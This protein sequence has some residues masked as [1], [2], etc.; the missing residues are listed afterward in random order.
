MT[1]SLIQGTIDENAIPRDAEYVQGQV[2]QAVVL[3]L[4][5]DT[6]AA[7]LSLR[8]EDISRAMKGGVVREYGKWDYKAEDEDIKRRRL[9]RMP[10]LQRQEISST[11][12]TVIS[13]TNRL[14]STWRHRM[15]EIMLYVRRRRAPAI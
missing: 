10:S 15:L 5:T 9:R 7:V 2:V 8:R 12:S 4:Y 14:R 6:F 3:E 11:R 1:P 13:T